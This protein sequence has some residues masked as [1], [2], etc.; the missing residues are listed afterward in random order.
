MQRS[1]KTIVIFAVLAALYIL[2]PY[3]FGIFAQNNMTRF[4]D[5][6]NGTLGD[7]LGVHFSFAQY[8]R[9]W[10]SSLATIQIERKA[11]NGDMEILKTIPVVIQHG[12]SFFFQGHFRTGFGIVSAKDIALGKNLPY[13]LAFHE[14]VGFSGEHGAVAIISKSENNVGTDPFGLNGLTLHTRSNLAANQLTF[15][16]VSD[17]LYYQDPA[18]SFSLRVHHLISAL[19]AHYLGD[20]HWDLLFS[21]GLDNNQLSAQ[22]TNGNAVP[23]TINADQLNLNNLH[24][25]TKKIAKLLSEFIQLKQ[26][27]ESQ[28]SAKPAA[29]MALFQQLLVEVIQADTS[30]HLKDLAVATPMGQLNFSYSA[31][32]PTLP[33]SHDY[34][35]IATRN[36][37]TFELSV[38]H[39]NYTTEKNMQFVLT[40]LQYHDFDN[41]V[42]SRNAK[43]TVGALDMTNNAAVNN[44]SALSIGG[45]SY[46][47]SSQ[48]DMHSLSQIMQW[49]IAKICITGDCVHQVQGN[50]DVSHMNFAAFRDV[51]VATQKLVQYNPQDPQAMNST[52]GARWVDVGDAYAKLVL[53]ESA[54]SL[55]NSFMTSQG[56]VQIKGQ[57]SW[58][59]TQRGIPLSFSELMQKTGYT[60]HAVFPAIYVD[61]FIEKQKTAYAAPASTIE[62]KSTMPLAISAAKTPP[63]EETFKNQVVEFLQYAINQGYLKK[64]DTSYQFDIAGVGHAMKINNAP[65]KMPN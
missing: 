32:F 50:L 8:N 44:V 64:T 65:W 3:T 5:N 45:F 23:M 60:L 24:F 11:K 4:L 46:Q 40:A 53:P 58:T 31:S 33:D 39:W 30:V 19:R 27:D 20:R 1:V 57:L 21:V 41:T 12:P 34:F 51:A 26:A 56:P 36:T 15:N 9:G 16:L 54:I 2:L 55:T 38:P 48:G 6:E 10:F 17:G 13:K 43:L 61:S 49:Q 18:K 22:L 25:D 28:Q 47:G 29:W 63:K 42:F 59:N 37:G 35:D 14:T 7:V 52:I 62:Q